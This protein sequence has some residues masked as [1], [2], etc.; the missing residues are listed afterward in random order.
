MVTVTVVHPLGYEAEIR[1]S[2]VQ[3]LTTLGWLSTTGGSVTLGSPERMEHP[4]SEAVVAEAVAAEQNTTAAPYAG[5][6]KFLRSLILV[7][8]T[9]ISVA[10]AVAEELAG[11]AVK[12][13]KVDSA[14]ELVL[15]FS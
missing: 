2:M 10:V 6:V 8:L 3:V 4:D 14:E 5:D 7:Y 15:A 1:G 11:L 9:S 13:A 12:V